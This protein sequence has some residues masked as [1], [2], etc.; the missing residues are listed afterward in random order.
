MADCGLSQYKTDKAT[1]GHLRLLQLGKAAAGLDHAG[2]KEKYQQTISHSLERPVDVLN[3]LP[4]TP[5][6]E[7]L[8]AGADKRPELRQLI[9]PSGQGGVKIV[10]DPVSASYLPH[11]LPHP[12]P[13]KVPRVNRLSPEHQPVMRVRI[14]LVKVITMPPARVRNPLDR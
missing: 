5:A 3:H 13:R 11:L 1:K 8:R 2:G 4:N 6:L 9:V 12:R 10:Y 14:S 7:A